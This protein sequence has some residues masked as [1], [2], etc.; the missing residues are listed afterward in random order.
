MIIG[1]NWEMEGP[2]W[3]H[4][5]VHSKGCSLKREILSKGTVPPFTCIVS[6]TSFNVYYIKLC[7]EGIPGNSI[8]YG[9]VH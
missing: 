3:A 2:G 4:E 9:H 7:S 8:L 6:N 1:E 5:H